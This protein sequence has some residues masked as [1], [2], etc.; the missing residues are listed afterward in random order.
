MAT[1]LVVT[2]PFG[3]TDGKMF[4]HGE[5]IADPATVETVLRGFP[6]HVVRRAVLGDPIPAAPVAE[7]GEADKTE[8]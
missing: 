6:R 5:I 1:E 4:W 8:A 3:T 7:A 2:E